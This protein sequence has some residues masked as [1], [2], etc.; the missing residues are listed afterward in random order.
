MG[1]AAASRPAGGPGMGSGGGARSVDSA[2]QRVYVLADSKPIE[3]QVKTGLSDGQ[4]TEVL[5]GLVE[6]DMV[7]VGLGGQNRGSTQGG[8]RLRL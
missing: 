4:R 2:R 7:I 3:R 8:P 6:G 1:G 5:E